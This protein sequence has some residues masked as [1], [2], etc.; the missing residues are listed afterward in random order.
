[1][2]SGL[3]ES[4]VGDHMDFEILVILLIEGKIKIHT[5]EETMFVTD[6]KY[7]NYVPQWDENL[8]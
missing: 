8:E 2:V 3:Y 4:I 5:D 7:Y 1:M 6:R